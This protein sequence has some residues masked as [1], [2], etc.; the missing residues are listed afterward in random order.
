LKNAEVDIFDLWEGYYMV[1]SR[2]TRNFGDFE[3]EIREDEKAS[4]EGQIIIFIE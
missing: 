2:K 4:R 1:I 3:E